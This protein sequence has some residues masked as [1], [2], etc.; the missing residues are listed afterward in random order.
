ME[1]LPSVTLMNFT[2][3]YK[4][5]MKKRLRST[6]WKTRRSVQHLWNSAVRDQTGYFS[7]VNRRLANHGASRWAF[8]KELQ[9]S[10]CLTKA[11]DCVFAD[12]RGNLPISASGPFCW[13]PMAEFTFCTKIQSLHVFNTNTLVIH[14]CN[15]LSSALASNDKNVDDFRN[16]HFKAQVI[17]IDPKV[18]ELCKKNPSTKR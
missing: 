5:I 4:R 15:S 10:A 3:G 8:S 9:Y 7:S 11:W 18:S 17:V 2:R 1:Q 14:M 13:S 16:L 12:A 6:G